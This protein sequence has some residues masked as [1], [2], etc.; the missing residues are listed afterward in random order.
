MA[1][2]IEKR[3]PLAVI[4]AGTMVLSFAIKNIFD[5]AGLVTGGVSGLA[6]I[7][8]YMTR[9]A[10]A[11]G[12]PL[13]LS[14]IAVNVPLFLFAAKVRGMKRMGRTV[15]AFL[16]SSLEL[17]LIPQMTLFGDDLFL[18]A[19]S[20]GICFGTGTGLLLKVNAT[21]GGTDMLGE[22]LHYF[23]PHYS[24]P[25]IIFL[26]DGAVVV[27]GLAV[28]GP[29]KTMYA[30]VSVFLAAKVAGR[31]VESGK[32]AKKAY[33]I[34]S[35]Y[36]AIAERILVELGRGVTEI[37]S[38]GAFSGDKRRMLFCVASQKEM[39]EVKEIVRQM[40]GEAFMIVSDAREV[41]GEGFGEFYAKGY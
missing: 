19:V 16:L 17:Y 32:F 8:K 40:D 22:A 28:F 38:Y 9:G 34:S 3:R 23:F 37:E 25:Q 20:G 10:F 14:N 31:I 1:R 12:I 30:I 7:I 27:L 33:V 36:E 5:P 11:E 15:A 4:A 18:T 13:W 21:S 35:Q 24:A 2:F 41:L 6:I 29:Q 26:L 39:V